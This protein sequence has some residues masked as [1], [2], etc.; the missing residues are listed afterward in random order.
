M[1]IIKTSV[2]LRDTYFTPKKTA[3]TAFQTDHISLYY[4][5]SLPRVSLAV[6]LSV[7]LLKKNILNNNSDSTVLLLSLLLAHL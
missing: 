1:V 3:R 4:I 7:Q 5:C 2:E 6:I